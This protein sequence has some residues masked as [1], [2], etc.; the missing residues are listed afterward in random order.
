MVVKRSA[1]TST[2]APFTVA[3]DASSFTEDSPALSWISLDSMA[4]EPGVISI[5]E[6]STPRRM[7][8]DV[9]TVIVPSAFITSSDGPTLTV[10]L[11]RRLHVG[12]RALL[13]E[14]LGVRLDDRVLRP[15]H[16]GVELARHAYAAVRALVH[17]ERVARLDLDLATV[18]VV[19]DRLLD[20]VELAVLVDRDGLAA[21]DVKTAVAT[22]AL[23]VVLVDA[24]RTVLM[25]RVGLVVV[26][27]L[28]PLAVDRHR[29]VV[30]DRL[31][32]VVVDGVALVDLHVGRVAVIDDFVV[33]LLGVREDPLAAGLVLEPQLVEAVGVGRALRADDALCLVVGR[34]H[35]AAVRS[36]VDTA[37]N[38]GAVGIAVEECDD[39]LHPDPWDERR[40]EAWSGPRVHDPHPTRA[41]L[42]RARLMLAVP[43]ELHLNAAVLVRVDL[44]V[45]GAD[46]ACR[47][48]PGDER[49]DSSA[50]RPERDVE[51][52]HLEL[53]GVAAR[54]LVVGAAVSAEAD[55]QVPLVERAVRT[56][57]ELDDVPRSD[58]HA[59]RS[60]LPA[61]STQI[62][63]FSTHPCLIRT[64]V[65]RVA[66]AVVA[67]EGQ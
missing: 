43:M 62:E 64:I 11:V 29:L 40:A 10:D 51:R 2:L 54:C 3:F 39:D 1:R 52:N 65:L 24:C 23:V 53:V 28:G 26:H 36:V 25:D 14:L 57:D 66:I 32:L 58:G 13:D 50:R 31:G 27:R 38:E 67:V 9:L 20:D 49:H 37:D 46:D 41:F 4:T 15:G 8:E 59:E 30:A 61:L 5:F 17:D 63:N 45:R 6:L 48:M 16:F 55:D 7:E 47:L 44:L 42:V 12:L 35:R 60:E 56:S 22:D 33:V 34:D 18:V 19:L 21:L